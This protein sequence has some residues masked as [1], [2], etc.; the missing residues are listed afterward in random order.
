[1]TCRLDLGNDFGQAATRVLY[2]DPHRFPKSRD[3]GC[4]LGLQAGAQKLGA[5]RA[6]DAHQQ[7]LAK[8][9]IDWLRRKPTPSS[10]CSDAALPPLQ[11]SQF[12]L[13]FNKSSFA[14]DIV[15]VLLE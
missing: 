1:M 5:K 14:P 7:A 4:Y 11:L 13:Q 15:G 9:S 8:A 2:E 6:A 12:S 10:K 3:V